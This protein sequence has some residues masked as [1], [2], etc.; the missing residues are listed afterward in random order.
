[1]GG[2]ALRIED[3][4]LPRSEPLV[5]LALEDFIQPAGAVRDDLDDQVRRAQSGSSAGNPPSL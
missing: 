4:V 2:L 1:L 5:G 3:P